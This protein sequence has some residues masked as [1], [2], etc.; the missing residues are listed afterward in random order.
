MD[1][2]EAEGWRLNARRRTCLDFANEVSRI[3][4]GVQGAFDELFA[5]CVDVE[6]LTERL[7]DRTR[8]IADD[9]IASAEK[10]KRV[11]DGQT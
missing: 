6:T 9:V 1:H 10:F 11:A 2:D 7:V 4:D 5:E 3:T 8:T